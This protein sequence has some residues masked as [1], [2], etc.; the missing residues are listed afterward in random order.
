MNAAVGVRTPAA[1]LAGVGRAR[2]Q[3][4]LLSRFMAALKETR[5]HEARLVIL[6]YENL[7]PPDYP[8]RN[9]RHG[10]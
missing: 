5:R 9:G 6:R 4:T 2:K 10:R 8:W 1:V 3:R 7:L